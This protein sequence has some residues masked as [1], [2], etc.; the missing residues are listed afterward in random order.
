MLDCFLSK[1]TSPDHPP[2][3][4]S[5][6]DLRVVEETLG[7][8]L[9][10][11]YRQAV[12]EFGLP[13]PTMALMDAIVDCE[14]ELHSVWDFFSPAEIVEET[15]AW[16]ELGLPEQLIAIAS[17]GCGN[18]FCSSEADGQTIWF[19]DH[20]LGMIERVAPSFTEWIARYCNIAT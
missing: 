9:P 15:Q 18:K 20:D 10:D 7:R 16:R 19:F 6:A 17:D 12:L 8:A 1:W 5:E 3:D 13:R 14:L 4:V 2:D 11:D